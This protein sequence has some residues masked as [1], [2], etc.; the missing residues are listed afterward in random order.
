VEGKF[1]VW[2]EAEVLRILGADEGKAFCDVYDVTS[3][4]NWEGTNILHRPRPLEVAA[5]VLRMDSPSLA[6]LLARCRDKLFAARSQRVPP[7]RDDKV[8][9]NWNGLMISAMSQAACVLGEDRYLAAARAAAQFVLA[10]MTTPDGRLRHSYKDGQARF[11]AYLDDYACFIDGLIDLYQATFD[12]RWLR[13]AAD[14]CGRM[15]SLFADRSAGGFFFTANDQEQ[16]LARMKDTQDNATPSGTGMAAYLL[17][18][19]GTLLGE[20]ELTERAV[21]TLESLSGQLA[22]FAMAS[23]QALLALDFILG[24]SLQV[25]VRPASD[26]RHSPPPEIDQDVRAVSSE[27]FRQFWPNA[28]LRRA[29]ASDTGS[30]STSSLRVVSP[31][32]APA[33]ITVIVCE[34]GT[35][36]PPIVGLE[37]WQAYARSRSSRSEPK[38]TGQR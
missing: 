34:T 30:A 26:V 11:D 31:E 19:L 16:L 32:Q 15:C 33:E 14:L 29:A 5:R 12:D 3:D 1:F 13:S 20:S 4:G 23:G 6:D 35:C 21:K 24:P 38:H 27:F 36:L 2:S 7:G 18:R 10:R 17:A 28:V 22:R 37:Q 25:T 9:V 8:L